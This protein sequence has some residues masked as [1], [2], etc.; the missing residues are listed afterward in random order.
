LRADFPARSI[1]LITAV[2]CLGTNDKVNNFCQI[3]KN[4][5][6]DFVVMSDSDVRGE[7]DYLKEL[8]APFADSE[9]GAVTAFYTS[10]TACVGLT[11]NRD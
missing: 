5:K 1:R 9:V 3:V 11:P 6:C 7:P 10:L 2:P 8:I 4:A